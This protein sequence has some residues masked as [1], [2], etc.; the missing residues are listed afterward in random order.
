[1]NISPINAKSYFTET[2]GKRKYWSKS[3]QHPP[4]HH[5][6]DGWMDG[7]MDGWG[8]DREHFSIGFHILHS[9]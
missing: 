3:F 7:W 1:M 5:G 8:V 6:R 2:G 9:S 4:A